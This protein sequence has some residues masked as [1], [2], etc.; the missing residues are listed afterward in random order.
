M[1]LVEALKIYNQNPALWSIPRKGHAQHDKLLTIMGKHEQ[2]KKNRE[3][4]YRKL[5]EDVTR[6]VVNK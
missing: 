6:E 4:R 1:R 2:V 5:V 3:E